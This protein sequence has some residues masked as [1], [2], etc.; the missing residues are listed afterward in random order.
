MQKLYFFFATALLTMAAHVLT[1][2]A[3]LDF[4][5]LPAGTNWY[6]DTGDALSTHFIENNDLPQ[7]QPV[8]EAD[9][10]QLG[11][12]VEFTPTRT[13]GSATGLTDGDLFGVV[14]V[15]VPGDGG[16]NLGD[17]SVDFTAN[18]PTGGN[19]VYVLE[20]SDGLATL[21]F[22]EMDLTGTTSPAF[23]MEYIINNT[24]YENSSGADDR[25]R[26][27]LLVDGTTEVDLLNVAND[28]VPLTE[29]WTT[30]NQDLTAYI[31]STVQL[32]IEFDVNASTEEMA[33]DNISFTEGTIV[34]DC[35]APVINGI[36]VID[37]PSTPNGSFTLEVDGALN[38]AEFWNWAPESCDSPSGGFT[39]NT[40]ITI[41]FFF[42]DQPYIVRAI[43]GCIDE[44]VCFTFIPNELFGL[45][46]FTPESTM[47]CI[48]AGVQVDLGGGTPAGGTYSGPGVTD[49]GNGMTYTFDPVAAGSGTHTI[50]YLVDSDCNFSAEAQVTVNA[51]PAVTFTPPGPFTTTDGVQALT[52]GM[53][54]GGTYS[55]T[56]VTD[57]NF[58]PAAAGAGTFT[59]TYT[60]TDGNGCTA[61]AMGD[62]T[63]EAD[64]VAPVING[65]TIV[66]CSGGPNGFVTLE[67][68]GALNGADQWQWTI[69]TETNEAC[70]TLG[71]IETGSQLEAL[72]TNQVATYYIRAAGGCIDEPVCFAYVPNELLTQASLSIAT[73]SYC[74][75]AGV[76]TGLGGG[77]PTGGTYS[78]TGVTDDG[79]G[80]TF[81]FDP[82]A[83]GE[84]S[85]TITYT[86]DA[87]CGSG[88]ATATIE[89]FALPEVTFTPPGPF[90]TTDAPQALTGGMPAGGTY[91]GT[92]VT[93][94]NF[95]PAA[96]GAGT[97]AITYTYTDGNG[98]TASTTGDI[99][100]EMVALPG[101]ACADANDISSLFGQAF[102]EPQTSGIFDNTGY[103]A[104]DDPADGYECFDDG[105]LERT[106]WYSFTGDG[107]NYRIKTVQCNATNYLTNGDTQIAI[108]SGDCMNPVGVVCNEDE[109]FA[110]DIYNAN[111]EFT[112]EEGVTY[113]MMIDGWS[114]ANYSAEGEFCIE[115]TNLTPSGVTSI[116]QT[117][118]KVFPNPTNGI[119]NFANVDAEQVEVFDSAGQRVL[120]K[121]NPGYRL[122]MNQLPSG[123]YFLK[124][125]TGE[126][127]V[128]ARV[129]KE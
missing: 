31:G 104:V 59:I 42:P 64:C 16:N 77:T 74:V 123:L 49:D 111:V 12:E 102:D 109:D 24:S 23:S 60:Y 62:I 28:Q 51:L 11:I 82:A 72:F 125:F 118:I 14:D 100:V 94:N 83:A 91:S 46:A 27:Y 128:S 84:G 129:V 126:E 33:I 18:P 120:S 57:N 89:V 5:G 114:G 103:T 127:V 32:I 63:V 58:D 21:Y 4:E 26:I 8:I 22:S 6:F 95:D 116:D 113:L 107:N 34:P 76:Q 9:G 117:E 48:D 108:Y 10:S 2:Q 86:V 75:D 71:T 73:N 54:E 47:Y 78:G 3:T 52:G 7:I 69:G 68:D 124:I 19:Q 29:V 85:Q 122:D 36:T 44:P 81:S 61:S 43:G 67:V 35:V 17:I 79:N 93:D 115:V 101:D 119:L 20:D 66:D 70:E 97:F 38:G 121:I 98:C 112:A 39:L 90:M 87:T 45:A 56:G 15:T 1:A 106:T 96:A 92:G 41:N 65:I 53:P 55:G 88:E 40:P 99:T 50:S 37:C 25:I 105:T 110:N 80:M 30:L 13:G